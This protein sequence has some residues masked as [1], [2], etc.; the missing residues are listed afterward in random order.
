MNT[1]LKL[2]LKA[3]QERTSDVDFPG[4]RH[5]SFTSDEE[6][7]KS[8]RFYPLAQ[9]RKQSIVYN[10]CVHLYSF[11]KVFIGLTIEIVIENVE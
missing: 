7:N 5:S 6:G 4:R 9:S 2:P 3:K 8:D 11:V 1:S 10:S